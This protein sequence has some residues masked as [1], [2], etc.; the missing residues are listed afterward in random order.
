MSDIGQEKMYLFGEIRM[1]VRPKYGP[2][3]EEYILGVSDSDPRV[4]VSINYPAVAFSIDLST[5]S[6]QETFLGEHIRNWDYRERGGMLSVGPYMFGQ[7]IFRSVQ[8]VG[9]DGLDG[10]FYVCLP[11]FD[12]A[13]SNLTKWYRVKGSSFSSNSYTDQI[14]GTPWVWGGKVFWR[15][16]GEARHFQEDN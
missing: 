11:L 16:L 8:S 6:T 1:A 3:L 14:D 9:I 4:E 10:F 15:R 7:V 2:P 13:G 5:G 12:D